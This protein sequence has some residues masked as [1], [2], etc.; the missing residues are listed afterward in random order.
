MG[1][2]VRNDAFA[3]ALKSVIEPGKTMVA[4]IGSGTGFLSFVASRLGAKEC[5]LYEM[6][7]DIL[8]L[9]KVLAKENGIANCRFVAGH[10]MDVRRPRKA[11]VVVS[12]TLGNYAL[13]EGMLETMNDALERFLAPGGT[14][15]PRS[16]RQYVVPIVSDRL[17]KDLNVWPTV[18]HGLVFAAA[19]KKTLQ[20]V[21]VREIGP[22][23]LLR[24]ADAAKEWDSVDFTRKNDSVRGRD[25]SWRLASPVTVYG[26]CLFWEAE[27]VQGVTLS[28]SPTAPATHWQ[29][30]YLPVLEP[31]RVDAEDMLALSIKSDTRPAVKVNVEWRIVV[32]DAQGKKKAS[33]ALDMRRG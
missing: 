17:W 24:G 19:E 22:S 12:E 11:D 1:D 23:D 6:N 21:Y 25:V 32:T 8:A 13:E 7:P 9:S 10:S 18:D 20:N 4:D 28:T 27:L 30:I 3:K 26:F 14:M 33:Q 29:Q 31:L 16:L 2:R 15:I 5:D